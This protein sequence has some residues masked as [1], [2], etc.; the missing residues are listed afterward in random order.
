MDTNYQAKAIV[1][2]KSDMKRMFSNGS[3]AVCD[4]WSLET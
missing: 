1:N 4:Q 2:V 3:N